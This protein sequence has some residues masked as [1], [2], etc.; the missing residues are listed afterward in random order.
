MEIAEEVIQRVCLG[1]EQAYEEL[2]RLSWEQAVRTSWLILRNQHDAEEVAQDS[3]L[4]L[5][6]LQN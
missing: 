6:V 4:K 2:F 1:D 5:S 3:F